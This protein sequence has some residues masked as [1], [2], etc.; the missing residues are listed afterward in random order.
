MKIFKRLQN[1]WEL[2]KVIEQEDERPQFHYEFP[3]DERLPEVEIKEVFI[4]RVARDPVKEITTE[5]L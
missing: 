5:Q 3:Q 1:L 4:P 2:S